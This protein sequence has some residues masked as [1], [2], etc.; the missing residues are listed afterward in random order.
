[1]QNSSFPPEVSEVLKYYVYAYVDPRGDK[2]FYIGK[3]IG[4]RAFAHL[5]D[6]AETQKTQRIAEIQ[7]LNLTPRIDILVYGLSEQEALRVEA[8][9]IDLIGIHKLTNLVNGH[10]SSW[11]G[12][13]SADE[14]ITEFAAQPVEIDD[15]AITININ[16]SYV[17]GM[18]EED[19]YDATRGIWKIGERCQNASIALA[20]CRGIV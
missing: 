13:R 2:I 18:S 16:Q 20:V 5:Y 7:A 14:I 4:D 3:G 6:S 17:Y 12:R 19:L 1:M 8:I 15:R 9:C 11:G 10:R